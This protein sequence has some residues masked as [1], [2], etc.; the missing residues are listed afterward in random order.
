ML[1]YTLA[2]TS[3]ADSAIQVLI[4]IAQSNDSTEQQVMQELRELFGQARQQTS[5]SEQVIID[6]VWDENLAQSLAAKHTTLRLVCFAREFRETLAWVSNPSF[7]TLAAAVIAKAEE[8]VV[9]VESNYIVLQSAYDQALEA[10]YP[11][12]CC[13]D[14]RV[15]GFCEHRVGVESVELLGR[16]NL[17]REIVTAWDRWVHRADLYASHWGRNSLCIANFVTHLKVL[18]SV[19]ERAERVRRGHNYFGWGGDP[20]GLTDEEIQL[21]YAHFM[22]CEYGSFDDI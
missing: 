6:Q 16:Y 14:A 5:A 18:L 2:V 4:D 19:E 3:E 10:A 22:S 21:G 20:F 12:N 8:S 11:H 7:T 13:R 17:R 15:I 9:I 1:Q